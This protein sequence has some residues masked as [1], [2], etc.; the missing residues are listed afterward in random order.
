MTTKV[1]KS[2]AM[3]TDLDRLC[4][5]VKD[6]LR[7][8]GKLQTAEGTMTAEVIME[9]LVFV[10]F[11][12]AYDPAL[13]GDK[14]LVLY[15]RM[16]QRDPELAAMT[17]KSFME[18]YQQQKKSGRT[19]NDF[20]TVAEKELYLHDKLRV[21]HPL[22]AIF[23]N[24]LSLYHRLAHDE[25]VVK[26][27]EAVHI[28]NIK[29]DD[30]GD[31][32]EYFHQDEA[33]QK[34][35]MFGAFFT[36]NLV[37]DKT[38]NDKVQPKLREDGSIPDFMDPA[39]G[40]FKFIR[41]AAKYLAKT[42][43]KSYE[44]IMLNHCYGCEI[45][46]KAYRSMLFNIVMEIGDI[47]DKVYNANSL[48]Y[49][50]YGKLQHDNSMQH[51][52]EY[53]TEKRY[54]YIFAN[55]PFGLNTVLNMIQQTPTE[56][57][58]KKTKHIGKY[59]MKTVKTD[60]M[61]L[62]LI[63]H[64]LKDGGE[65]GIVLPGSIFNKDWVTLRKYWIETCDIKSITACPKNTFKNTSIETYIIHFKKG[66]ATT[67]I[68]YDN[69]DG[70]IV[71]TRS[72]FDEDYDL[73][74]PTTTRNTNDNT[75]FEH[76]PLSEVCIIQNGDRIV[77]KRCETGDIPVYGG[78]DITFYTNT[79]NRDGFNIVV[80]RFAMSSNCVRHVRG[81]FY[82]N[83][84][85]LTLRTKDDSKLLNM[86]L[87]HYM[88]AIQA[89]VYACNGNN[90]CQKN[91]NMS[92]FQNL[93]IPVPPIDVQQEILD[94]I[95]T[96]PLQSVRD[97]A[98]QLFVVGLDYK[99]VCQ[100][101]IHIENNIN[102]TKQKI[103]ADKEY[104]K[105]LLEVETMGCE[106]HTLETV[107]SLS[108]GFTPSTKDDTNYDNGT[109]VWVSI[110][111][112]TSV[113]HQPLITMSRTHITDKAIRPNKIAK[114]GSVLVSFKLSVGK[115]AICGTDLYHN[116]AIAALNT[117]DESVLLN[118]YLYYHL[119]LCSISQ[120]SRQNVYGADIFNQATLK[121]VP[122]KLPSL[123]KQQSTVSKLDK[124]L[125]SILAMEDEL[126]EYITMKDVIM[127]GYLSS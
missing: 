67:K 89:K 77:K 59:H 101:L 56:K 79:H 98:M 11:F 18:A 80:S 100:N 3:V 34:S 48:K 111:D 43:G 39:A 117:K 21:T 2:N 4:F 31:I 25:C 93:E 50:M 6:I 23:D 126:N 7:N 17:L 107:T 69:L 60:G 81:K 112:L 49:L 27:L 92:K 30:I 76:C 90:P 13:H 124:K 97:A 106:E 57:V 24:T 52:G 9:Y 123:Q 26:L 103:E 87:A 54:D 15:D 66:G 62:Q 10:K 63:I 68:V 72:S 116:E 108:V 113:G 20:T 82:L 84:S 95:N 38:V 75:N 99:Q 47:S 37:C 109:H 32:N 53:D 88:S 85:G 40:S 86:F 118:K 114:A 19:L 35:Q 36:P 73:S 22:S 121:E 8:Y 44:E 71:G 115:V 94:Y 28:S 104:M 41:N 91:M 29:Y 102:L 5:Q 74:L 70:I 125:D 65:A 46:L 45:E 14:R 33:K 83:D 78:G 119:L 12:E 51:L 16:I 122:I 64:L 1:S 120:Y 127:K 110:A 96:Q 55:P 105:I 42:T 58:D 61:F